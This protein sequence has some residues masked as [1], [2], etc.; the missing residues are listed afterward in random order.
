MRRRA[1]DDPAFSGL[2]V[3]A[4][5][6]VT[7]VILAGAVC[8][9]VAALRLRLEHVGLFAV[10]LGL[11]V[12]ASAAKIEL[13]LGRSQSNLSLSHAVN[14]WALFALGPAP[15]ALIAAVSAWAQCT[16]RA[17]ARNPPHRVVFSIASL[18]VTVS[19]AGLP[20]ILIMGADPGS[21]AALAR[22]AAVVA[23]LYFFVNTALVAGAIALS[24]RQP[25]A[26]TWQ[27]NFLWSAPSYLAGAAL[28]AIATATWQR[29]WF[30]WLALLAMPL[31][32]V[33]RSYHTVVARLREEQ[34][35]TLRAMDVQLATIEALALAIEAKAGCTPEHIRSIQQYAV[36][37]AEEA[38]LSDKDVQAVR[39]AALLHDVGN[40]AVPEHILSKPDALTP[41][42][43]DRVKTHPRVG[44]EILRNVPFG[45]PV[46][47]LVLC[48]HERWDGLGYPAAL[49]GTAIPVGAR[50]L[51][52]ADCYSTLQTDRP[53][54]PGRSAE[55]ALDVLRQS[56]GKAFDPD[57]VELL[58]ARLR[59]SAALP[60]SVA[61]AVAVDE[62]R[63]ALQD[64]AGTHREE[65]TLYEIAQALG[66][67]LGVD[68]A[69]AL[70]ND[71]V[72]R[73][74]PF[75]TCALFLG[76]DEDGYTCRSAHGPGT[77]ALFTWTVKSWSDLSLRLPACADG[78]D[79]HGADL[80]S[81]LPC[82]LN[83]EGHLIGG[84]VV[85][86]TIAGCFTDEHRR[87]LGRVS[88]QAAA[89]IYNSTRFE[90]TQ[91]ESHT[92]PLTAL[93]N[94]RSLDRQF[95][96]GLAVA[97][98]TKSSASVVVLD[99]DRLK[100]IN[101]T[102]G[103]DAGDRA[104][105][106]VGSVLASTVRA[107]DLCARFAGDEFIVVLWDCSPEHEARRVA[108]IQNAV[109]AYPFEPR[110]G[111]RVSLSIS[112]G[113]SRF[114]EDGRTFEDLLAS[115]DERMYHDKAGRRSRNSGRH[116]SRAERA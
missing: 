3:Q 70:I 26:R 110:P 64:I 102:Y 43:F 71:K 65:Q 10:L 82:P 38:G 46:A 58:I 114:P 90:Q 92:D 73:L 85:Y 115:A 48:H 91:H 78:R 74:V 76:N 87:V 83:F 55:A 29:G 27:R 112:A 37:L 22:A 72:S 93:P 35:E 9:I 30:G 107:S 53:Y 14:F 16:L 95:E 50:I 1:S 61:E 81:L 75:T 54:R 79:A 94:R 33:F 51:A 86:H 57:L 8:L 42:E 36:I 13:P 99:L 12:A 31:Y 101:D 116:A 24:T 88:E 66:S 20:L 80:K 23:P 17:G 106:A 97:A 25:V 60:P 44:A 63:L 68:G 59:T 28:A 49:C 7:A 108:D 67:N 39:T 105:R 19:A 109:S 41:E 111:V 18:T 103:H 15:T 77:E 4:C 89:V 98:Q 5:A 45:A 32:L 52:I 84:L 100:E 40:M 11:A 21:V 6:Y 113:S 96:A 69:M 2:P 56:A 62:G 34:D 47:E 104:L